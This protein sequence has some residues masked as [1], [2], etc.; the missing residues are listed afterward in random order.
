MSK[1]CNLTLAMSPLCNSIS[2]LPMPSHLLHI[3]VKYQTSSYNTFRVM[4]YFLVWFFVKSRQTTDRQKVTH[5][6]PPCKMHRWAQKPVHRKIMLFSLR[7]V[8]N[9]IWLFYIIEILIYHYIYRYRYS[10][11]PVIVLIPIVV[12]LSFLVDGFNPRFTKG[13]GVFYRW[14]RGAEIGHFRPFMWC[15]G[16]L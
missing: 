9:A 10:Y 13:Q 11:S 5:I 14:I 4:N 2:P 7:K 3:V 1:K 8:F 16:Y 15:F 12:M 6:S